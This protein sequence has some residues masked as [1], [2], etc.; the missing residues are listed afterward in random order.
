MGV[1]EDIQKSLEAKPVEA[2]D[3]PSPKPASTPDFLGVLQLLPEIDA[4]LKEFLAE[5]KRGN[6]YIL[7][8]TQIDGDIKTLAGKVEA[9]LTE[10]L[11]I[12]GQVA[13]RLK[14]MDSLEAKWSLL[15]QRVDSVLSEL[16]RTLKH[17]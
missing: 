1:L 13:N 10:T 16:E 6:D 15:I 8:L 4:S 2:V 11:A 5:Q 9:D 14:Q 7:I 12:R 3:T 17:L